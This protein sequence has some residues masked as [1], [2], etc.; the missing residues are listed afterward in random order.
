M[1]KEAVKRYILDLHSREYP[2]C[3]KRYASLGDSP[4]IQVV[5]GA[6]RVG[7]TYVLYDKMRRLVESGVG[8]D[9]ILYLNFEHPVLYGVSYRDFSGILDSY[10]SLYPSAV[11]K[12]IY[13]FVDEPQGMDG[14]E[15]A[16]RG[17]YDEYAWPIFITG[18]SSKLLSKEIATSLRGRSITTLLMPLSFRE[19]LDFRGIDVDIN[20]LG[21][22]GIADLNRELMDYLRFG[23]YP[24]VVLERDENEKLR[25]LKDYFD[26]TIY[27][28][29]VERYS[30]KNPSLIR[31]L[32]Q[33]IVSCSAGEISLNK[34]F[35]TIKSQGSRL[36]KNTLYEYYSILEDSFFIHSLRKFDRSL[37][38]EG[39]TLPKVYLNDAGF[40][41]LFSE[42]DIGKRFEHAIFSQLARNS[43]TRPTE[44]L[45]YWKSAENNEVDFVL[46]AGGKPRAAIQACYDMAKF[47]TANREKEALVKCARDLKIKH[48]SIITMGDDGHLRAGDIDIKKISLG[49]WLLGERD[50]TSS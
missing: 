18:S 22:K 43:A 3:H 21:T 41:N 13:L 42:N 7:K 6:R 24:E 8:K 37:K 12:K 27:K 38:K 2:A 47:Q 32:I 19:C 35:H 34:I 1:D 36:S 17:V 49:R 14:W 40:L 50:E 11:G 45:N 44:K 33:Y 48:S 5:I 46:S 23:G 25:I 26:L 9:R 29:V 15:I 10:F 4:K 28:D 16:L 39:M 31:W 20:R 30:V